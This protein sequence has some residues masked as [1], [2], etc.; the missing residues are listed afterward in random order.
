MKSLTSHTT[1]GADGWRRVSELPC[2]WDIIIGLLFDSADEI[3][4]YM[5]KQ[6]IW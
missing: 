1:M 6:M 4:Y 2:L 5:R 3:L